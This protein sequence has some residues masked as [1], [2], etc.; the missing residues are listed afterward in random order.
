MIDAAAFGILD[1]I[2]SINEPDPIKYKEEKTLSSLT[3][4]HFFLSFIFLII[5]YFIATLVLVYELV[6][7]RIYK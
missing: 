1:K 5:G 4:E 6:V 2:K 7:H 3:L